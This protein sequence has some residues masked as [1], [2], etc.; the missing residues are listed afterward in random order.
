MSVVASNVPTQVV[1]AFQRIPL[2]VCSDMI[3]SRLTLAL[4][5]V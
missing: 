1:N 5:F 4:G 3:V 2:P